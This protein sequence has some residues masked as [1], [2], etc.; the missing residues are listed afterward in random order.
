MGAVKLPE[1]AKK[2]IYLALS[3]A[4][5]YIF[6]RWMLPFVLPFLIALA[7]ARLMEPVVKAISSKTKL[8]RAVSSAG[9]TIVAV[10]LLLGV[11]LFLLSWIMREV[12]SV[13]A[14]MPEIISKLPEITNE[15]QKKIEIWINAA[16]VSLQDFLRSSLGD[17]LSEG[18]TIPASFYQ[19]LGGFVSSFAAAV[20][21]IALSVVAVVLST[22]FISSDYPRISRT[23]LSPF[24]QRVRER[25]LSVKNRMT[26]TLGKWLRA[27][28]LLM[29]I[30][31]T[32]LLAGFIILRVEVALIPATVIAMVDAL[33]VLGAGLFLIPWAVYSFASGNIYLGIGL[34]VVYLAVITVRGLTEPRL[35]GKQIGLHPLATFIA[36]YIGFKAV[37]VLGM[38]VF[39]ILTITLW[40]VW[41]KG[42]EKQSL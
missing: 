42:G 25:I 20:P 1:W 10:A 2:L 8:P 13:I 23:L 32:L 27:Q 29:L 22:Y 40:Q 35:I 15:W 9:M 24:P 5:I 34:F 7:I 6:F 17:I 41:D 14:R 12:N 18:I 39:P 19:W 37:G 21:G 33:P 30:T 4:G 3:L 36:M 31:F 26:S 11:I 38:V 16:P 28:A